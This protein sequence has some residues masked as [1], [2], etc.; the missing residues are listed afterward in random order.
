MDATM[1]V[2]ASVPNPVKGTQ[3]KNNNSGGT[4][5]T[6]VFNQLLAGSLNQENQNDGQQASKANLAA[7]A[8]QLNQTLAQIVA[9]LNSETPVNG[10]KGAKEQDNKGDKKQ[11]N[12][13]QEILNALMTLLQTLQSASKSGQD[14][15]VTQSSLNNSTT[16]PNLQ[17][18][19]EGLSSQKG[20]QGQV[21]TELQRIITEATS[22]GDFT[23]RLE[24]L[25]DQITAQ[26]G[27]DA[28]NLGVVKKLSRFIDEIKELTTNTP[29]EGNS[30]N[31]SQ[32]ASDEEFSAN[33]APIEQVGQKSTAKDATTQVTV[34]QSKDTQKES[35]KT[36]NLKNNQT[37]QPTTED[38]GTAYFNNSAK[39]VLTQDTPKVSST[40]NVSHY[41][42][43]IFNQIVEK[44]HIAL[45]DG[46]SEMKIQL[47]PDFL[48]KVNMQIK[49]EEGVITAKFAAENLQVKQLI[50]AN[51]SNLR[52]NLA[53]Q[54][55]NVQQLQVTV[56]Q[57]KDFDSY[58]PRQGQAGTGKGKSKPALNGD[59]DVI[60]AITTNGITQEIAQRYGFDESNYDYVV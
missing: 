10:E 46:Q 47:Q 38:K 32:N 51:L 24:G 13:P 58:Q 56:G 52:Q 33:A 41:A 2:V 44:A 25:L 23:A 1:M 14:S 28:A 31:L 45:G 30:V 48:G 39:T 57:Q 22:L 54:G 37:N 55:F 8:G 43:S 6:S 40:T 27:K 29:E 5:E 16:T 53:D 12:F 42:D 60:E 4:G 36:V 3:G 21:G 11:L 17:M 9:R 49:V 34:S 18:L 15:E 7:G 20:L 19:L 35:L 59:L 50:E 26:A